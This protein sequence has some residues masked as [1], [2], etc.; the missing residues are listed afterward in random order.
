MAADARLHFQAELSETEARALGGIDLVL[1]QIDRTIEALQMLHPTE[2]EGYRQYLKAAIP[3][4]KLVFEAAAE[5]PS[6]GGLTRTVLR[7]RLKGV[8]TLL[9][10]SQRSAADVMRSYFSTE[11]LRAPG[12]AVGPM[13]WGISPESAGTAP[14]RGRLSWT[15]CRSHP[16]WRRRWALPW[17][18][19]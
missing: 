5:P 15:G 11:A 12:L 18:R 3:A 2:V 7:K 14:G 19:T 17:A 4:V 9:R 6:I 10:W 1:S 8:S 16:D 13:V